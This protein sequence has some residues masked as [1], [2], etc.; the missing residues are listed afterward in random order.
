VSHSYDQEHPLH[1]FL[2]TEARLDQVTDE[3]GYFDRQRV[4][5]TLGSSG[6]KYWLPGG[7]VP[8]TGKLRLLA[9]LLNA[10]VE[11]VT[12]AVDQERTVRREHASMV[13]RCRHMPY[14]LMSYEEVRAGFPC[15]GCGRPWT[16]PRQDEETERRLWQEQHG[17]CHAGGNS[18]SDGPTHCARCC[19]VPPANPVVVAEVREMLRRAAEDRKRQEER[20]A[21]RTPE[22]VEAQRQATA[23]RRAKRIEKLEAEL[24]RLRAEE[25]RRPG[26]GDAPLSVPDRKGTPRARG[27]DP[28]SAPS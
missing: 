21:T 14:L 8:P 28:A 24:E 2:T 13:S 20:A 26:D 7:P 15:P 5:R 10:P 6:P 9:Q 4:K 18:V 23:S 11:D 19:G 17:D 1:A 25:Q 27:R 12:T 3:R 16:G 22:A